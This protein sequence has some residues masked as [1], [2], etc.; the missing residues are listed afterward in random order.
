MTNSW[1]S[2][3]CLLCYDIDDISKRYKNIKQIYDKGKFIGTL[4]KLLRELKKLD[5]SLGDWI[6]EYNY[7]KIQSELL[8]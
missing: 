1:E 5:L 6:N 4:Y 7:N 8:Q 3:N 2:P